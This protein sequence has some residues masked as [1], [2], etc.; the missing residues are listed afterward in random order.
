MGASIVGAGG[1][2]KGVPR[3]RVTPSTGSPGMQIP[4]VG[5]SGLEDGVRWQLPRLDA[6]S[7]PARTDDAPLRP[8]TE[9]PHYLRMYF[10]FRGLPS[11]S[12]S[13]VVVSRRARVSSCFASVIHSTYSR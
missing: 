10:Q 11:V 13:M 12:H 9:Y 1:R 3:Q 8:V 5:A 4:A 2:G 7:W 6:G